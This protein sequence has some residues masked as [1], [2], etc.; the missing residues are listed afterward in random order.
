[1]SRVVIMQF[2]GDMNRGG[3]AAFMMNVLR[4]IDKQR[5]KFI[6][7]CYGKNH[8]DYE[9]EIVL[10]GGK[11]VRTPSVKEVGMFKHIID[12]KRIIKNENVD[13][14]HTHIYYNSMF[15]LIAAKMSNL[16]IRITHSHA[17]KS[18]LHP[19][20]SKRLFFA[21]SKFIINTHST[22][23]V[24]CSKSAGRSMFYK[25]NEFDIID[26]G[27]ILSD[28][29]YKPPVRN[30][31]RRKL[32][33]PENTVVI[34]HIGRIDALKNQSYIVDIYSEYVKINPNS[35]L[36]FIGDGKSRSEIEDK[37]SRLGMTN[38]VLFLG[39]RDD[40]NDLYSAMDLFIFPSLYE[41]FGM[42]LLEAQANGLSF[43]ASDTIDGSTKLTEC[44]NYYSLTRSAK[45]WA[46]KLMQL[47][48]SRLDT[49]ETLL[50]S[51]YNMTKS[52]KNIEM[53]YSSLLSSRNKNG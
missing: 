4:N 21:I 10:L 40:A 49:R 2:A 17:V 19:S 20:M 25:H 38:T 43:L 12:I 32:N 28:F 18:E 1:M 26:N 44:A 51:N 47:S 29:Y 23:F 53:Y 22:H 37:V 48:V 30:Y 31:L 15:A 16:K 9:D 6:F 52:V 46:T 27:I 11:I 14:L 45:E 24:A 13:I 35:L 34:G 39:S 3:V 36:I 42:V 33:I 8:F 50:R 5:F 7:I 41:G